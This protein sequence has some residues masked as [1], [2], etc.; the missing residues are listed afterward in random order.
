MPAVD[1]EALRQALEAYDQGRLD[2]ALAPLLVLQRKYPKNYEANEALGSLYLETDRVSEALSFLERAC[3]VSPGEALAHANLG[4]A[5]L[6]MADPGKAVGELQQAAKLEPRNPLTQANL[7]QALML[8]KQPETAARAFAA[9]AVLSPDDLNLRYNQALALYD[10]DSAKEAGKVLDGLPQQKLTAEMHALAGDADEKAGEFQKALTHYEAAARES[11]GEAN[12]YALTTELLRHWNWDEAIKVATYGTATWPDSARFRMA[13]GI[14]HY[15]KE[16]YGPAVTI[17]SN[18]L[19]IDPNNAIVADLLGRSCAALQ[20]GENTGC[21][22]VYDFAERHPAN[23]T[24]MMYAAVAILHE[25]AAKQDLSKAATLL[26]A[27]I[28]A[29]PRYADA[30]FQMGVLEQMQQ[31]W[32]E[33]AAQLEQ[34]IALNPSGAEAHYRLSRAYAHM[35]R[36]EAAQREVTLHQ[37][38]ADEAKQRLDHRLQELMRFVLKPS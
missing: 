14:A 19:R 4:A 34:S 8:A 37:R 9:A 18:E 23:A 28:K 16:D 38:Y 25:P 6:K 27:S 21:D 12:S 20:D 11:P 22:A 7:G 15:G 2:Q 30:Y 33:S 26:Q 35:G 32:T 36:R 31:H 24:M 29:D 1:R 13:A 5:Y 10:A 3:A 17:F